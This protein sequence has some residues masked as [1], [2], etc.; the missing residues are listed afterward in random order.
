MVCVWEHLDIPAASI[1]TS[2]KKPWLHMPFTYKC[3]VGNSV[4][5]FTYKDN[6]YN[7]IYK[8]EKSTLN[9]SKIVFIIKAFSRAGWCQN[10]HKSNPHNSCFFKRQT[11]TSVCVCIASLFESI[12][13]SQFLVNYWH[14]M[15]IPNMPKQKATKWTAF[16]ILMI[17][18]KSIYVF[19]WWRSLLITFFSRWQLCFCQS[20]LTWIPALL[21]RF[22]RVFI[23]CIIKQ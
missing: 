20:P 15:K 6:K 5:L 23:G 1:M 22:T 12:T 3:D 21:L 16:M 17:Q 10:L 13:P 18:I 8:C 2:Q 7:I 19:Q 9:L 11:H 14:G 4:F